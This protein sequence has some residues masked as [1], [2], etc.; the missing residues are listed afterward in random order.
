MKFLLIIS[1]LLSCFAFAPAV[2][3]DAVPFHKVI[4]KLRQISGLNIVVR[5]YVLESWGI[6]KDDE[7]TLHLKN[8]KLETLLKL[9]LEQVGE[10]VELA[11][12]I[13]DGVVIISTKEDLSRKTKTK[14]YDI[15][16]L[17]IIAPN[18]RGRTID[19]NNIGQ[20]RTQGGLA[21]GR[22]LR[23]SGG[24]GGGSG[25]G[26]FFGGRGNDEEQD[27]EEEMIEPIIRLIQGTVDPNNWRKTG[28]VGSVFALRHQLIVTHTSTVHHQLRNL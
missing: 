17:M 21:G 10:E 15:R 16:D 13:D 6:E 18:F 9:I 26:S 8:I 12:V 4:K 1:I 3:I 2:E 25:G 5:W 27:D 11:Y 20:N 24:T 28:G 7:I 22:Y 19:L 23:G 14:V